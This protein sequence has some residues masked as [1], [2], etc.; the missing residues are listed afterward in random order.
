M[1][2]MNVACDLMRGACVAVENDTLSHRLEGA[3]LELERSAH[4]LLD[5]KG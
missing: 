2:L 4:E 3:A 5:Q 1:H